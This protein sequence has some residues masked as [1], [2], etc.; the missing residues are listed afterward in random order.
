MRLAAYSC[1][2]SHGF[3]DSDEAA[4]RVPSYLLAADAAKNQHIQSFSP[5]VALVKFGQP[6]MR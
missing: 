4:L 6:R 1:G 2:S 3:T 5:T